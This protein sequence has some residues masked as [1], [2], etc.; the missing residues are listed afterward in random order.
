[1]VD[2]FGGLIPEVKNYDQLFRNYSK[3]GENLEL[4]STREKQAKSEQDYFQFILTELNQADLRE[5]EQEEL[6]AELAVL[7]HA[8]EIKS[9]LYEACLYLQ[10]TENSIIERL[11]VINHS[12]QQVSEYSASLKEI[13]V[14]TG[15]CYIDLSELFKDIEKTEQQV[16]IDPRRV[17][18]IS[19]RL[20]LIYKLQNKHRVNSISSLLL[21]QNELTEK[22]QNI[23]SLENEI[24]LL[25][26]EVSKLE[27]E[28]NASAHKL[29]IKRKQV[30]HGFQQK[31]ISDLKLLGMPNARL[32]IRNLQ[33]PVAGKNGFDSVR[34]YFNANGA[35]ELQELS[36][37]ASGGEK[38]RLMLVIKSLV[39]MKNLLP[40]IIFDEIDLGVSG[41]V[42]DKVG[43]I[44]QSLS[45]EMQVIVITH[46]PQIA[47][48]GYR[49]YLVFKESASDSA[50]TNIRELT[51]EERVMEIAKLISGKEV[52]PVSLESAKVLL[53]K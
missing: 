34:F 33:S 14:R 39:S 47:G 25:K 29:T 31:I 32:E 17:D 37:I 35:G 26:K 41:A 6:E 43:S 7:N 44:L 48:K 28:V 11:G 40:T 16:I 46:L 19:Q 42:A 12:L 3:L 45:V 10:N 24:D 38:S 4:L 30:F 15:N 8:E 27:E 22:L 21:L 53:Q 5:N 2:S 36:K 9:K 51:A 52:T 1:V 18:L 50:T 49:H 23:H 20:D 13:S